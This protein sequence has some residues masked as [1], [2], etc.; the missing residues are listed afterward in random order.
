MKPSVEIPTLTSFAHSEVR[1]YTSKGLQHTLNFKGMKSSTDFS[2]ASPIQAGLKNI[3]TRTTSLKQMHL[4][5]TLYH[6]K[7]AA[8]VTFKYHRVLMYTFQENVCV[9]FYVII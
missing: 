3:A 4:S 9:Y 8:T 6:L 2:R 7:F 1:P 5:L